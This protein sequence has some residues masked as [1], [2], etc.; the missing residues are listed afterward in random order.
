MDK[1]QPTPVTIAC[2]CNRTLNDGAIVSDPKY[3]FMANMTL[4][5]G[6]TAAPKRI[7]FRCVQ[8]GKTVATTTDPSMIKQNTT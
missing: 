4:L 7:D 5:F 6:I 2:G 3:G 8:C 1:D